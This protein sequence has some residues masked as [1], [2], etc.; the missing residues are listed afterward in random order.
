MQ[1]HAP[2]CLFHGA[3]QKPRTCLQQWHLHHAAAHKKKLSVFNLIQR[4]CSNG[5]QVTPR[6]PSSGIALV[7]FARNLAALF[8]SRVTPVCVIITGC[9]GSKGGG[10]RRSCRGSSG[11]AINSDAISTARGHWRGRHHNVAAAA[12]GGSTAPRAAAA[13]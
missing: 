3:W 5:P 8:I 11:S 12:A 7:T 10:G 6:G 4:L 2:L 1:K 13:G 9:Q